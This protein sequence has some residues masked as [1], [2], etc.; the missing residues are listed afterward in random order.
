M[1][2]K[3]FLRSFP[4]LPVL[5]LIVFIVASLGANLFAPHDPSTQDILT[6]LLPPSW[7]PSGE[8]DYLLG[9][10]SLGRDIFSNILYGGRISLAVGFFSLLISAAIGVPL[11]LI[12][13]YV[14]GRFDALV[15][16]AADVQLS[17][18]T[19][20]IALVVL[21]F[22]GAGLDKVILV[23]GIVGWAAYARIMRSSVL[24]LRERDFVSGA[25]ALGASTPRILLRHI[26][27]NAF[28]PLL[29]QLSV[30]FPRVVLLE[31]TLSFLGLGVS[32][33]TPSL[34]L[35]IAGGQDHLFSGGWWLSAFPGIALT[36]L[37]FSVNL[38][39]DWLRDV[40]DPRLTRT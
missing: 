21:A 10:D 36:L 19:I 26:L 35:M 5:I 17:L 7:L 4:Y 16:R 24:Q 27:P 6:S 33:S 23:I 29:V 14:G 8:A 15:M 12:A 9:T 32:I 34:G 20:L 40:L 18:P 13:G 38:I 31:A 11:G 2:R 37:V 30:D 22:L 39:G 1:S 3:R 25:R 28:T